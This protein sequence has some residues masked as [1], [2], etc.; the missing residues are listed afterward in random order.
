[1]NGILEWS[2]A[3]SVYPNENLQALLEQLVEKQDVEVLIITGDLAQEMVL[4]TYQLLDQMLD[5]CPFPVYCIPGNHDVPALMQQA[6]KPSRVSTDVL[7]LG[8]WRLVLLDSSYPEHVEGVFTESDLTLLEKNLDYTENNSVVLFLHHHPQSIGWPKMDSYILQDADKFLRIVES[9]PQVKAI[10][11]GHIHQP[12]TGRYAHVPIFGTPA[13]SVQLEDN[14][15]E[16]GYG[17]QPAWREILLHD[18]GSID[19][20]IFYL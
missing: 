4:E 7:V 2:D 18:D 17:Y 16:F 12:Y 5:I 19:S 10:F 14:N 8:N 20:E 13:T 9:Y 11:H 6:M 1:M 15:G 3:Q